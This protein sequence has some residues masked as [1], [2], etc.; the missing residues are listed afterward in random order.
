MKN[1]I[2][3]KLYNYDYYEKAM[4]ESMHFGKAVEFADLKS[5]M[6]IL[7]I[8]CGRGEIL[9]LCAKLNIYSWGIDFSESALR[10]IKNNIKSNS[11]KK[12]IILKKT[13]ASALDF[14]SDYFDAVFL[15][16]VIEHIYPNAAKKT[17]KEIYRV[18]KPGG[19]LVLR[20]A[21]NKIYCD[22]TYPYFVRWMHFI[23]YPFVKILMKKTITLSKNPRTKYDL[24]MHVNEQTE[25]SLRKLF[26][27]TM[28][29]K[30]KI[31][32]DMEV[33]PRADI[34][35]Y[36]ILANLWPISEIYP[37]KKY[38]SNVLWARTVK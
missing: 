25:D 14:P 38:F 1:R 35:I 2:S 23:L 8:G 19:R 7:D 22:I 27:K 5:G 26:D 9:I 28:F 31:L 32:N 11:Y 3:S 29:N 33:Y 17:I 24:K 18:L 34:I 10:I 36:K 12:N 16:D 15:L 21:P 6:K 13:D 30:V 20:T 37:V 4:P